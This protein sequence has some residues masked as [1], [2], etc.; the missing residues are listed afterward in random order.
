MYLFKNLKRRRVELLVRKYAGVVV[1]LMVLL[2]AGCATD[3]ENA[4]TGHLNG[5]WIN[6]AND[7]ITTI[8]INTLAKTIEY[9]GGY[10]G[11]IENAPD[12][13]AANGAL[14]IKFTKYWEWI[15][16]DGKWTSAE[17]PN[18][19]CIGK[20]GALYWKGLTDNSVYMA[21]AYDTSYNHVMFDKL[22]TA[23]TNFTMDNVGN[24]VD[25]SIVGPYTK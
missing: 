18:S 21:D 7:Y 8:K 19:D 6:N 3:D 2:L 20:Y 17:N 5:V 10:E 1:L 15:E 9:A 22:Q 25:W 23:L 16:N 13:T 14:I 24:Y 11:T 12:F 4:A